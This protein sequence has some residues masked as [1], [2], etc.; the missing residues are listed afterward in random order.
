MIKKTAE[1]E[2]AI[3][4]RVQ[5]RTY[6]EILEIVQVSK[7]S[8]SL[9]LQDV[10]LAKVQKQRLTEKRHA[11]Q[12][13]GGETKRRQRI[14]RTEVIFSKARERV[15]K[16]SEREQFLIGVALY[17]GEGSKE[18]NRPGSSLVFGNTDP[19]MIY[20]FYQFLVNSL[21]IN[22]SDIYVS[23]YIHENHKYRLSEVKSFWSL[24]LN[25]PGLDI[26]QVYFKKHNPKTLHKYNADLYHGT[27]RL[28][29]KK[30]AHLLRMISGAIY[31]INGATCRF[32]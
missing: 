3:E 12:L 5:G 29:V 9:W 6:N 16:L 32:V 30:S 18:R 1:R 8:L 17:W 14:E 27:L 25:L 24:S 26:K 19:A 22:Q 21:L 4:L 23:L 2:K 28:R 10:G 15:G 31:A 20:F 7:S 13:R 11:A